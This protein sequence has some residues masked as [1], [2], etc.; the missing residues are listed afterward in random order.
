MH[1]E[2]SVIDRA[3]GKGK[4]VRGGVMHLEMSVIDRYKPWFYT[5]N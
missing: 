2:M 1:L 4:A 5:I 3:G